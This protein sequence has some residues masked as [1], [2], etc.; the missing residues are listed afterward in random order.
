[1]TPN[2]RTALKQNC[3]V[4]AGRK[5]SVGVND[6]KTTHPEVAK[7]WASKNTS[8]PEEYSRG[9]DVQVWWLGEG[10]GHEYLARISRK[11]A[12]HGCPICRGAL[13]VPGINDLSTAEEFIALEY[14]KNKNEKSIETIYVSSSKKVWWLCSKCGNSWSSV[15]RSRTVA[16]HG[17]SKC[18]HQVEPAVVKKIASLLHNCT[19]NYTVPDVTWPSGRKIEVDIFTKEET[20]IEYDGDQWH[21]AS[22]RLYR[23]KVKSQILAEAGYKIVRFREPRCGPIEYSHKNY[24]EVP[25]VWTLNQEYWE[26][27]LFNVGVDH[28]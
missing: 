28:L 10:C 24:T 18:T 15:V 14:D 21:R 19:I 13:V 26:T 12:G 7:S 16:G 22:D 25:V 20:I 9:S 4:C 5:V 27:I 2:N 1:M 8:Q 11:V 6:L 23:D 3:P 17:C